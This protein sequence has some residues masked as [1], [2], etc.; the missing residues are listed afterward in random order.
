[1]TLAKTDG[2]ATHGGA[3]QG[4]TLPPATGGRIV[5]P[6]VL[7]HLHAV[8]LLVAATHHINA[9]VITVVLV[10]GHVKGARLARPGIKF[11]PAK[12]VGLIPLRQIK[13][14]KILHRGT[15][16]LMRLSARQIYHV[17]NHR[18]LPKSARPR[19]RW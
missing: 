1:M 3:G 10:H 18:C 16:L 14:P 7:E 17:P 13:G 2:R 4:G 6:D 19:Q 11:S 5:L 12:T 9:V 15:E 8:A